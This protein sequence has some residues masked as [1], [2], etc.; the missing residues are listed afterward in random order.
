MTVVSPRLQSVLLAALLAGLAA[1]NLLAQVDTGTVLGLV[2]DASGASIPRAKVTLNNEG[3]GLTATTVTD[4][5]GNYL[6]PTV[7][8]GVYSVSAEKDGF[9]RSIRTHLNLNIQQQALVTFSLAPGS[10]EQTL[11]VSGGSELLQTQEASV[12]QVMETR[13][14]R[15]LPLNGR[16]YIFLAQLSAGVTFGQK[17]SRGEN[18]NGRFSANGIRPT[19][20]NYL[21]DG[22]D[23][24]SSIVSRQNGKD[25][26]LLTP[27][28][29]VSEFKVQTNN[30]SAEFGRAAG[31]VLN[32]TV[33]SGTNGFHGDIWEFM[34]NDK[35]DAADF[36]INAA[37][38]PVAEYRRNQFG[39]TQG[40]PVVIPQLYHGRN[41][42]FFFVDYEGTRI[43][44]GNPRTSTV[45]TAAQKAS[46]YSN[47]SD[48]LAFQSG[49]RSD[50][51]NR[52]FASGTIF[53][54]ATTRAV[55][56]GY[57]RDPFAGN[58]IPSSR[59]D[60]NAVR[61]LRLLPNPNLP[62]I[63]SNYSSSPIFQD[64]T[65]SFD[66][67]MDHSLRQQDQM[68]VRFSR[69]KLDRIH[70]GPFN[71]YA[72]GGDS[73]ANSNLIDTSLNSVVS[74]THLF[75]SATVNEFR[76]GINRE[77]AL[78]LQ[79]NG[80]VLGIPEQFGIQGVPQTPGNGGLP[81]FNIASL[82]RFGSNGFLPSDKYGTTPQL[83]DDLSWNRGAHSLRFGF[84][85]QRI[86]VPFA[87]PPQSRGLFNFSGV[88]TSVINKTD[89]TTAVTQ[90]LL[91]PT[92]GSDL[93]GANQV[94]LSNFHTHDLRRKYIGGYAQ[95][96]WKVTPQLTV[97]F[98]VRWD[99][100]GFPYDRF[101]D[102]ANFVPGPGFNGGTL[103]FP[104]SRIGIVPDAYK[105]NLARD[106][107]N[108]QS[109]GLVLGK[110]QKT[111]F[112]PRFGFAWHPLS[113]L[114]V[115][116]GYGIFYGGV[117]EIGG[118]PLLTENFPIEYTV[119]RTTLTPQT[120]LA[121]GNSIG[122]LENTFQNLSINPATVNFS[123]I[124]L[125]GFEHDWKTPYTQSYNL[126][127]QYQIFTAMTLTTGYV[128]STTRH[129]PVTA[130]SNPVRLILPPGTNTLPYLPYPDAATSGGN[131][132]ATAGSSNYNSWQTTLERRFASGFSLLATFTWAKT[133]T[134]ARDPLEATIGGY[135][136][137]NL[138]GFGMKHDF[139]LADFNVR[140][141]VHVSGIYELPLGPGKRFGAG[142]NRVGTFA[143]GGWSLNWIFTAQDGQPFTIGCPTATTAGLG[144]N[145]FLTLNQDRY[146][147]PHNVNHFLNP[148]AFYNPPAATVVGQ[149]D[150]NPL[151]GAPTQVSGPPFR[152]LD[153]SLFKQFHLT[154]SRYFE[155]RAEAFNVSNTANFSNPSLVN[156]LDTVNFGRITTTR[157]N[158]N[159]PREMQFGLKFYW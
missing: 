27:V 145:A 31:A 113:K 114:V 85:G 41:R 20:N 48:L 10:V 146:S 134:D 26:V 139:A 74:E 71:G 39:F 11:T 154:E 102:D 89:A 92:A 68:F 55:T 95:D 96:S 13:T 131:Y 54:P 87:Q 58:V 152:R 75:N 32:A 142:M 86:L 47:F 38:Q 157:D 94:Q 81:T 129:T 107:V 19:Q 30:Y 77:H 118:S 135:R 5:K 125:I 57:V 52:S 84:M 137:L 155:F 124:G 88:Y 40:G 73:T 79:P 59:L 132:T 153:L 23:N 104:S 122:L 69:S 147:G 64:D 60:P 53:D 76:M 144:C 115:R 29:A 116:G 101:G 151:G 15:D 72:D 150:V 21:L 45:P 42:T 110:A 119:T 105:A 117:E 4:E 136:G 44:Q 67:R 90:F 109:S 65:N 98:G 80:N 130:N 138:P 14:I 97:T 83:T 51:L 141:A 159:D 46:G 66:I 17:D 111:N 78:W 3:T 133:L 100:F 7:K 82:T 43:R 93:V 126:L 156:Y 91:S 8:V 148:A 149:K 25:Y 106:G 9:A 1:P 143:F 62:G 121:T 123:G 12:G 112:A 34:R 18:S 24:N 140:R 22:M 128:G 37:G 63:L 127:L 35:L 49:T 33:K 16:N 56:G 36:F 61:L 28:D 120:P 70:P 50:L 158:P 99:Y 108:V 6:F 103:L 2:T